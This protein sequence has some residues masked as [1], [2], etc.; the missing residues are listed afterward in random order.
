MIAK[1]NGKDCEFTKNETIVDIARRNKIAIPTLC[2][3]E[4]LKGQ[5]CC[6]VCIVE[7]DGKVVPACI[8]KL[9]RDCTIETETEKIKDERK[10]ILELLHLRA[11]NS[12]RIANLCKVYGVEP[13]KRLK[14]FVNADKCIMCGLCTRACKSTGSGAISTL[15]RGTEKYIGTPYDEESPDC[16][17]CTSCAQVCPTG[18]ITFTEDGDTRNIW[19]KEFK[20]VHCVECGK[21]IGTEEELEYASK[22]SGNP[23]DTLCDD[24]RKETIAD[25]FAKTY[26]Y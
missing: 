11:P 6:R 5:G 24:C 12:E 9:T 26:G 21:V 7:Q 16:V 14:P 25:T 22:K 19:H 18:A 2:H 13:S 10:V 15:M 8:T 1:I 3:H 23:V 17:G 20:L 4:G